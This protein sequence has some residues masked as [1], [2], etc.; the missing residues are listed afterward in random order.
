[1]RE[2]L[3]PNMSF[4]FKCPVCKTSKDAPVVLV[5]LPGTEEDGNIEAQQ[6]HTECFELVAKMKGLEIKV[7]KV[8]KL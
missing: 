1:M 7:E 5:G 4:G 6:V 3:H 8:E 2:F